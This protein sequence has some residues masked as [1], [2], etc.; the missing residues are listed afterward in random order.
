MSK[1]LPVNE[2][3]SEARNTTRPEHLL[4]D[5][6]ALQWNEMT[7]EILVHVFATV[8]ECSYG[9]VRKFLPQ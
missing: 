7:R 2:A 6:E 9:G 5:T 8:A 4:G 3:R 1:R